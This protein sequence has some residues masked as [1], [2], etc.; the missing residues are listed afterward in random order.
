[1]DGQ[2]IGQELA[3]ITGVF[4]V[5]GEND[6][7]RRWWSFAK[8][9]DSVWVTHILSTEVCISTLVVRGRDGVEIK[10]MIDLVLVRRDMIQYVEDV[11]AVREMVRCL[12]DRYVV[13]CKVRQEHGLR[14]ER[15]WLGLGGYKAAIADKWTQVSLY[16]G[17]KWDTTRI[18]FGALV[19]TIFIDDI[20][21]KLLCEIS[22][23]AD[24]TNLRQPSKYS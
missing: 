7:V 10:S 6:N 16:I 20:D 15:W 21:K 5:P 9:G 17:Q 4:K 18:C 19:F 13:L 14:G 24:Y 2:E 23:D 11:R 3:G 12:S 8:K 1:M 22:K